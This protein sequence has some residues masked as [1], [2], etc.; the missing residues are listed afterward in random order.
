MRFLLR[1]VLLTLWITLTATAIRDK[2]YPRGRNVTDGKT[3]RV[4]WS[5]TPSPTVLPATLPETSM[6]A[7]NASRSYIFKTYHRSL[8]STEAL[9][10]SSLFQTNVS[11]LEPESFTVAN[12]TILSVRQEEFEGINLHSLRLMLRLVVPFRCN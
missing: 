10:W 1:F 7:E 4:A 2:R 9:S 12:H 6:H 3:T 11:T 8:R 5:A